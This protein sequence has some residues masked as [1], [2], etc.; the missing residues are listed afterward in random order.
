MHVTSRVR[1]YSSA[2]ERVGIGRKGIVFLEV[3]LLE[4]LL[5]DEGPPTRQMKHV[6]ASCFCSSLVL[7][8]IFLALVYIEVS[9]AL[10]VYARSSD[11][12]QEAQYTARHGSRKW[13]MSGLGTTRTIT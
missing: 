5:Q 12:E 11:D 1:I 7:L 2:D 9:N 13:L 4:F 10:E 6:T 8:Q 3:L